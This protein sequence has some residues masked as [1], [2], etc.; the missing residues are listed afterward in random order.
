MRVADLLLIEIQPEFGLLV[1][2]HTHGVHPGQ[3]ITQEQAIE[4]L[5][6]DLQWVETA[7]N[8]GVDVNLTDNQ[9]G[10]LCSLVYNIGAGAFRKSTLLRKLNEQDYTGA[11]EEFVRW[12]RAGG[13]VLPGLLRRRKAETELFTS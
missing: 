2:G 5:K 1:I 13:R 11:S 6:E 12:D 8:D 10:A 9:F 3:E 7:I 4:Y